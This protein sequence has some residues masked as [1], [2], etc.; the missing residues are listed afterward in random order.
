MRSSTR[1]GFRFACRPLCSGPVS[2]K[3]KPEA[4][5][6]P[7]ARREPAATSPA[8]REEMLDAGLSLISERGVAGASL[9]KLAARGGMS[10]PSLY[11]YF[12]SK[13]ELVRQIIEH[14]ASRMVE[15]ALNVEFPR[16]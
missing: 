8:R 12:D 4:A 6:S 2:M 14:C 13:E 7:R 9:R 3:K 5:R 1:T 15:S 11:H 10:Q 16:G